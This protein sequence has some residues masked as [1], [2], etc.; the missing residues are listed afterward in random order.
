MTIRPGLMER[1]E[2][3]CENVYASYRCGA[4]CRNSVQC[5]DCRKNELAANGGLTYEQFMERKRQCNA[6]DSY[7]IKESK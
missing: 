5:D 6:A 3:M 4:C 1:L 2:W 7:S